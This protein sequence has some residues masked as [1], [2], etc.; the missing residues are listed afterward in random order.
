MK[1]VLC[2]PRRTSPLRIGRRVDA[3]E[4]GWSHDPGKFGD[5]QRRMPPRPNGVGSHNPVDR[6]I[7]KWKSL[8]ISFVELNGSVRDRP[9]IAPR[10][11][12]QPKVR[13][14]HNVHGSATKAWGSQPDDHLAMHTAQDQHSVPRLDRERIHRMSFR[15]VPRQPRSVLL[16]PRGSTANVIVLSAKGIRHGTVRRHR[17]SQ[18]ETSHRGWRAMQTAAFRSARR[19]NWP[20]SS[21][22][23]EK[24]HDGQMP[25]PRDHHT[26]GSKKCSAE[27]VVDAILGELLRCDQ[28]GVV[29]ISVPPTPSVVA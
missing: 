17:F 14:I 18:H 10:G 1:R 12:L 16:Y 29:T 5:H 6:G 24:V 28:G 19:E 21:Y 2:P 3:Q 25:P 8:K 11:L 23:R 7:W 9:S 27:T 26:P 20:A 15:I 22:H 4:A 13:G